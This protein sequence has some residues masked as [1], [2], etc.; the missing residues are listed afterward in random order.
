MKTQHDNNISEDNLKRYPSLRALFPKSNGGGVSFRDFKN[1]QHIFRSSKIKI[2][3]RN[4][5]R[6]LF[7]VF[8]ILTAHQFVEIPDS[9]FFRWYVEKLSNRV[10]H[11][12]RRTQLTKKDFLR[13]KRYLDLSPDYFF[14]DRHLALGQ[15]DSDLDTVMSRKRGPRAFNPVFHPILKG[16]YLS[17]RDIF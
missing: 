16:G 13:V 2:V 8:I 17:R 6:P 3:M 5:V 12:Q 10:G 7:L 14:L 4:F 9:S 15:K 1:F 11:F